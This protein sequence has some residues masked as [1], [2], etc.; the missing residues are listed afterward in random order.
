MI[1]RQ[2]VV[3]TLSNLGKRDDKNEKVGGYFDHLVP[4]KSSP[5]DLPEH[6]TKCVHVG[7]FEGFNVRFVE[8]LIKYLKFKYF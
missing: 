1:I 6:E 4:G 7:S 5:R 3:I 8:R 2:L